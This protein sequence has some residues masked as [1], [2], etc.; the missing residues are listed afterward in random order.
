M[1]IAEFRDFQAD[2]EVARALACE[3][4]L[5]AIACWQRDLGSDTAHRVSNAPVVRAGRMIN[6]PIHR[7]QFRS[8]MGNMK[9]EL[10]AFSREVNFTRYRGQSEGHYESF[11]V[12]ANHPH[13]AQA[14]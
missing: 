2:S 4:H 3:T 14:F 9:D 6:E 8:A 11:F 1:P 7:Q 13:R 5:L 12:R 10:Q